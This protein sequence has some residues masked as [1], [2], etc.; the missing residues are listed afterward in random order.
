MMATPL[1]RSKAAK[2]LCV[3]AWLTL[4]PAPFGETTLK[5][6]Y[7]D[8]FGVGVAVQAGQFENAAERELIQRHFGVLVAEYQM[9]ADVIAP[10]EGVYDWSAADAIVEYAQANGMRV[11]G[12]ALVWHQS[13]PDW[14]LA[15]GDPAV[16]RARL[17]TY[18]RDVVT[19]YR[20]RIFAWDVVNEAVSDGDGP[21]RDNAWFRAT[22][23][24][25]IDWAFR[26]ARTADPDCLLFLN[27]YGT[28]REAKLGRLMG[29]VDDLRERGVPLDGIG[30]QFHLGPNQAVEGIHR[31]LDAVAG[32]GLVSHVT[33]LDVSAYNDPGSCYARDSGCLPELAGDAVSGFRAEQAHLYR[34]VFDAARDRP[35]VG[36][37]LVWGL[38]DGRSWLNNFPVRRRPNHP[39]L[40]DRSLE[41]KPALRALLDRDYE[42]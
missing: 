22:G 35:S 8:A 19:R 40:F 34:A 24:D 37:V 6:T 11:R 2:L 25:Y 10:R 3:A 7:A 16:I 33:E 27:D 38:H 17:E 28:E 12:H 20:G 42:P 4:G 39:L 18:V 26:A 9:K 5:G 13:T 23:P 36:A 21:Y 14:F 31:A 32:V 30:H 41:A 1:L 29:V 15:G